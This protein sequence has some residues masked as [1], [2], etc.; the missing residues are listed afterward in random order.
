MGALDSADSAA[1]WFVAAM[2]DGR[3]QSRS[4]AEASK[5]DKGKQ[6]FLE[7]FRGFIDN[8]YSNVA[9]R[10]RIMVAR[11][12]M[13]RDGK[14]TDK[15]NADERSE[16]LRLEKEFSG[17]TICGDTSGGHNAFTCRQLKHFNEQ[18][19]DEGSRDRAQ[20][21][22]RGSR[23]D[24]NGGRGRGGNR[25]SDQPRLTG[26][27][28]TPLG[29]AAKCYNCGQVGHYARDCPEKPKCRNC[30]KPGHFARDCPE[31]PRPQANR[32]PPN[33]V[34]AISSEFA[35]GAVVDVAGEGK[36]T[37]TQHNADGS[38]A[39]KYANNAIWSRVEQTQLRHWAGKTTSPAGPKGRNKRTSGKTLCAISAQQ[40]DSSGRVM[41]GVASDRVTRTGWS[42][43]GADGLR[44]GEV[45]PQLVGPLRGTNKSPLGTEFNTGTKR[46]RRP[47]AKAVA[48]LSRDLGIALIYDK[49]CRLDSDDDGYRGG[50]FRVRDNSDPNSQGRD[51]AW[52]PLNIGAI[53][54][55]TP[56][57]FSDHES[58]SES[59]S[60]DDNND[61][62]QGNYYEV[63]A[64]DDVSEGHLN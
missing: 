38:V 10:K 45:V 18:R 34:G 37:V 3:N 9:D 48:D 52:G 39:V 15:V 23:P 57:A 20:G 63:L 27:N 51:E 31:P 41:K 42:G 54:A 14:N 30:G 26:A 61:A 55:S 59:A 17:C 29:Q 1:T 22:G 58:D 53:V 46:L 19:R 49:S 60:D 50:H 28:S 64:D 13:L 2:E 21:R 4:S 62:L 24:S 36:A 25:R 8:K 7:K 43:R 5:W 11:S 35:V 44:V 6:L 16:V 12:K 33:S 32:R 56:P 40:L 47:S